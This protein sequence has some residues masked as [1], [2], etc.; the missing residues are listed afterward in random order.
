MA[1]QILFGTAERIM[2]TFGSLA[3]NEIGL[4]WG[5]EDELQHLKNTV[6]TIKAVLLDAEE[7]QAAGNHQVTDWLEKLEDAIYEADDLLDAVSTEALR[8]EILTHHKKAKQV[9]IF[10]SK[11][12]QFVYCLKMAHKIKAIRDKLDAINNDKQGFHLEVRLVETRVGGSRDNTHSFVRAEAVIGR[13]DD[14]KAVIH[15]LLDSNVEDNVSILPIVSIGGLG[16]TTLA[17]L[18]FNDDQIQNHFQLQMWVCVSDPFHVKN[19]VENILEAATK[20]KP[21]PA[22]MNTLV[23]KLKEEI[24]GKKYL[25]VLDD[26]WN[27]DHGKWFELKELLM[28]GASGSRILV[29]TRSEKV[30]R[31]SETVPLHSLKGLKE[32]DSWSLLKQLAFEKGKEPEE[33]SSIAAVGKE[34]LKKCSGVPLAIRTI[35]S[36]L[37]FKNSEVEWSSFK[38]NE[39]SKIPQNATDIIPTLKLSYHHLPSHLKH[40]FAYCSLFPKDHW[41]DKSKLIQLWIAQGFVKSCDDQNRCLEEVGNEYFMDLLWRSFFQEAKTNDFGDVICCKMHDLMHDLAISVAGS[42][43]TTLDDKKRNLHEKTRHVS[44]VDY[45]GFDASSITA[46]LC[47][48]S[49][50]RT[51]LCN[52]TSF[53]IYRSP[54][55]TVV[56]FLDCEAIFSSSKFLRVLDLH[57]RNHELLPSSIGKLKHLR[58]LD[59]SDNENLMKLPNCITKLQNLQTLKVRFCKNLKELPSSIGELK[60]LR[61]LDLFYNK[62]LK[63][64]PNSMSRLLNLQKLTLSYCSMLEELPKD[65]KELVNLRHLKIDQCNRLTYM[66][67]G[68]GLLTNLQTLSKFVVHKD[69]LSQHSSGL[70]ELEGLNN[71]RGDLDIENLR[72]GKDG[73]SE[74]KEANLKAKQHLHGLSLQW[75]TEGGVNASDVIVDDEMLLEVLQPHPNLKT[76]CLSYNL[77]SR[78]PSWLLSLT[79]LVTLRLDGCTKCQYLP[80]L[81]QL[82]S[83][84]DLSLYSMDAMEYISDSGDNNEFSS[85][86]FLSLKIIELSFCRNLKGWWRRRDSSVE[87][88]SDSQNSI[89]NT[90]HPLLPSFPCLSQLQISSC[91]MLT[92]MPT[93]PHLKDLSLTGT[94]LKPLQQT[95][96]MN[97]GAPQSPTSKATASS[98]STPLS[99]LKSITLDSIK[100]LETLPEEG[101]KNLTS[102]KSLTIRGCN[103]L[104]SL[105]QGIQHLAALQELDLFGCPELELANVEDEMQWQGLKSLLS[106]HFSSLPKL[107]SLPLGLQHG[108]TLQKLLISNCKNLT[109]IPE[110]IRNCTSLQVLE[111]D[112]CSSLTSL[113]EGMRSLTSLQRLKIKNSPNLLRRCQREAGE[114]WPKIAHIPEL[115]LQ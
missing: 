75:S 62:N 39:L 20:K 15:R 81:S 4:L 80:S 14:K 111:I 17:Q 44:V 107:V 96:M 102:L 67:R 31:I 19:I 7:K 77:G 48:A 100:D 73:A 109:A 12:N 53:F 41:F 85:S 104:N 52:P 84:K 46:S 101:L 8:R 33:T 88:N 60:H 49:S 79:N 35:G 87:V 9:R 65:M 78:L 10:F 6:S 86:F 89:E 70:K 34:I 28:G 23:S 45:Y 5:V 55:P 82:P 13:D 110:W 95:M 42:L 64:L 91:D 98:S 69:P 3:A 51:F 50:M 83:L 66:P 114:D 32:D 36:L 37:R 56:N 25:L 106:L 112:G 40:C 24:D 108:T 26:V 113:P 21:E 93:F 16:K 30:A 71:L 47:K 63:K 57:G 94:S 27:E 97:M 38:N 54:P 29:T 1:E 103:K 22:Q 68:L 72:H 11:S 61:Y 99:K 58:Y 115:E 2:E 43:I 105:S 90:E 74:C 76:L 18:I 59:L 92:S